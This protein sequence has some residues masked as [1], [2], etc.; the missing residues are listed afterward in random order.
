MAGE[1]PCVRT[2]AAS[3]A[4]W[5]ISRSSASWG[6]QGEGSSAGPAD[7]AWGA[8]SWALS[9]WAAGASSVGAASSGRGLSPAVASG[10]VASIFSWRAGSSGTA[11]VAS[12]PGTGTSTMSFSG[13]VASISSWG[14]GL[15]GNSRGSF[16][17]GDRG[18]RDGFLWGSRFHF[19][20]GRGLLGDSF[21][22]RRCHSGQVLYRGSWMWAYSSRLEKGDV[23][24][25][26][27]GSPGAAR[28]PS[29]TSQAGRMT[30]VPCRKS[31]RA[32]L[33]RWASS[34]GQ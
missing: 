5:R 27:S 1:R 30:K 12:S 28:L 11:G 3:R 34:L 21:L 15:L 29:F 19:L 4:A 8:G 18:F 13:A 22:P 14:A 24:P 20:L 7:S 6:S 25:S 33:R 26:G 23:R 17:P 9:S 31:A 2:P 10:A 32:S 16:F